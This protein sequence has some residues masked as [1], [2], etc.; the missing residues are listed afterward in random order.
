L[1][2]AGSISNGFTASIT[3]ALTHFYPDN[4]NDGHIEYFYYVSAAGA[5]IAIPLYLFFA[6]KFEYKNYGSEAEDETVGDEY[7]DH[8]TDLDMPRHSSLT[9]AER[10]VSTA[11]RRVSQVHI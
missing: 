5:A 6:S 9:L 4:L 3:S 8:K 1:L 7:V 10:R 2:A 11:E